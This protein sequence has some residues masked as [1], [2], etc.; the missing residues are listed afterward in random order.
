[1]LKIPNII[2]NLPSKVKADFKDNELS[3][4]FLNKTEKLL[5]PNYIDLKL[6]ENN[7]NIVSDSKN[8]SSLITYSKI[9]NNNIYGI[10]NPYFKILNVKG[11]GYRVNIKDDNLELFLGKSHSDIL[12]KPIYID[13]RVENNKIFVSGTNKQKVGDFAATIVR[14]RKINAYKEKGIYYEN[15][16]IKLKPGKSAKK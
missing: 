5:I 4:S 3:L 12:K 13:L 1:M 8:V 15:Q 16:I 2:I 10:Q 7:I 6:S 9:I 14:L 11:L